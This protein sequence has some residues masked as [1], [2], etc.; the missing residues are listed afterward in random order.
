PHI[1]VSTLEIAEAMHTPPSILYGT[2]E[3]MVVQAW[4]HLEE[5]DMDHA[6]QQAQATVEEWSPW[7][8]QLQQRKSLA[9]GHLIEYSGL[10]DQQKQIFGYWALNDVA[11]AYFIIGKAFDTKRNYAQ[12]AG[13]FQK[14]ALNYSL[15]Q[16]WDPRG[17]FW[18]P[19]DAIRVEYVE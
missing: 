11:A 16:I 5:G 9:I 6:I 17:W 19:L 3:D 12:A 14:I 2:S 7:A 4:K 8:V 1:D 15:A 10:E 13:A 18:S